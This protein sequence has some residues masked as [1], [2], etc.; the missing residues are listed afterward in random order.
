MIGDGAVPMRDPH[1]VASALA[2]IIGA[3]QTGISNAAVDIPR[4]VIRLRGRL[5]RRLHQFDDNDRQSAQAV[6]EGLILKHQAKQSQ[7]R[8]LGHEAAIARKTKK[9]PAQRKPLNE[10]PRR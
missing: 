5:A 4:A 7:L 8:T 2:G 6:L 1:D 10:K 3:R 9:L